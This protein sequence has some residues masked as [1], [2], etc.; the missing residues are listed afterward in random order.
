[1][2]VHAQEPTR[3]DLCKMGYAAGFSPTDPEAASPSAG[4]GIATQRPLGA[5]YCTPRTQS[6]RESHELGRAS[7]SMVAL[8]PAL[9]ILVA[10]VYGWTG[11]MADPDNAA[12]TDALLQAVVGEI[13]TWPD[14]PSV[15][16]GDINVLP[17]K[18]AWF[19]SQLTQGA[20][21]DIG[22]R[23]SVWGSTPSEPTTM[24]HNANKATRRD[25]ILPAHY[26]FLVLQDS[27]IMVLAHSTCT[28]HCPLI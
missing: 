9:P 27:S 19:S 4:V 26:C 6:F 14:M 10:T 23:A 7:L 16:L 20:W 2:P 21:L 1:M 5:L 24:A 11:A 22:A 17:S 28:H 18:L 8:G 13:K 3:R 25:F 15:I 12:R